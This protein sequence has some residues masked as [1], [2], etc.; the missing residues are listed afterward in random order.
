MRWPLF[1]KSAKGGG[2]HHQP[3]QRGVGWHRSLVE[4][5]AVGSGH[6][7]RQGEEDH[8][9]VVHRPSFADQGSVLLVEIEGC[10]SSPR[11]PSASS[12]PCLASWETASIDPS[13]LVDARR[14]SGRTPQ[15]EYQP[16]IKKEVGES[17]HA[18]ADGGRR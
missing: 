7:R 1:R 17:S 3:E 15:P 13:G 10:P 8:P 4:A 12:I 18:D 9:P 6:R 2:G 5:V 14:F 11:R 16:I